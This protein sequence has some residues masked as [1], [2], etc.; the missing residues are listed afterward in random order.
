MRYLLLALILCM[1]GCSKNK[2]KD[3]LLTVALESSPKTMDP[4]LA[5]DANGMRIASLLFQS[6]VS[7]DNNL[8]VKGEMA[9]SWDVTG[10][11]I[12]FKLKKDL[13]F[14]NGRN[15]SK[16]DYLESIEE[17]KGKNSPFNSAFKVIKE[18]LFEDKEDASYLTLILDE[19]SLKFLS[20][21]LPVLKI[22]PMKE[23]KEDRK[24]FSEAL[25][26]SGAY[27]LGKH[28]ER[29]IN[30]SANEFFNEVIKSKNIK[31][32]IIKDDFTRYQKVFKGEILLAQDVLPAAKI[33]KFKKDPD[34]EIYEFPGL[35]FSY[36]LF[37]LKNKKFE[38]K[39]LRKAITL[40][41]DRHSI[42]KFK[43]MGQGE[44]ATSLLTPENA[45]FN[46]S[47][48]ETEYSLKDAKEALKA[49]SE[50][51]K[52]IS[53][54]ISNNQEVVDI[55][56]VIANQLNKVGF[57][58]NIQSF[59]WG[60]FYEDI[61]KGNYELS[62]MRWVGA[63]DPDIYKMAFDTSEFPPGRNRGFYSNKKVDALLAKGVSEL[64]FAKRKKIYDEVQKIIFE[65]RPIVPLWYNKK[66]TVLS[67][68]LKG[69][70][71]RANGD[72]NSF[73]KIEFKD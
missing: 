49:L 61:K 69:Y 72:F 17:Y 31:F 60:T 27:V 28:D 5:T 35:S 51:E 9:E 56:K 32:E 29:E 37:N 14:S 66:V 26:G 33:K 16:E 71:P 43:L 65:E 13:K 67:S 59:E 15:V 10:N 68:R 54:K 20:S 45:Y 50:E 3:L 53:V 73:Y 48:K 21:D 12:K 36:L 22:L 41:V 4:R 2:P 19:M 23:L 57:K 58:V 47:L 6:L 70:E 30:L 34:F 42:I 46:K 39:N 38:N 7:L 11:K 1:I 64:D 24:A 55:A 62:M 18:A 8:K 25:F 44:E 63:I 52:T 40:G